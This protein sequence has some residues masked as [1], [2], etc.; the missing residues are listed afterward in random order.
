MVLFYDAVDYAQMH[1]FVYISRR[2]CSYKVIILQHPLNCAE[3]KPP[4][5]PC[6]SSKWYWSFQSGNGNLEHFK[7]IWFSVS[8]IC[9]ESQGH[10]DISS[11]ILKLWN[12]G[13][14]ISF[15]AIIIGLGVRGPQQLEMPAISGPFLVCSGRFLTHVGRKLQK[16]KH[17]H[18]QAFVRSGLRT[19]F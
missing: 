8:A 16:Q 1:G 13:M 15:M 12:Y 5:E 18:V 17:K 2:I 7:W 14:V 6:V 19:V 4:T 10:K 9:Y 3:K 11:Q